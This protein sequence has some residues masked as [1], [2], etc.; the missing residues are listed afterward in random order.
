[1]NLHYL[2]HKFYANIPAWA[3]NGASALYYAIPEAQRYGKDF[4][5]TRK[6]LEETE[7]SSRERIEEMVNQR[8][9][10]IVREAWEHVPYYREKYQQYGID[11]SE[12]KDI[13]DIV[14]L[15]VID[16]EEVRQ[17]QKEMISD[18]YGPSQ[19]MYLTTSG[20]TGNPLGFYQSKTMVMIEWAY[21]MHIWKRAG[22]LPSNS[23]LV[24]RG[25]KLHGNTD[26]QPYFYDPLR[27]ELSCDIFNMTEQNMESYCQAIELYHPE[28]I[29]GYMSSIVML[30]KYISQRNGGLRHQFKGVLAV[31]ENILQE[32]RDFVEK[33]FGA[34]VFSFYGHTERLIIAGECEKSTQYHIEPLYGYC[35]LL[36]SNDQQSGTGEITATGFLNDAMPFIRYRTGDRASFETDTNCACGRSHLRWKR[37]DGRD[38]EVLVANDGSIFPLTAIDGIHTSDF[39]NIIRYRFVQYKPGIVQMD[40]VP[41]SGYIAQNGERI[42]K[43]LEDRVKGKMSIN[44]NIQTAINIQPNGK[45]RIIE[46]HL[47]VDF[48]IGGGKIIECKLI[49]CAVSFLQSEVQAA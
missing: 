18:R 15:P 29:H 2:A 11:I 19:L 40:I 39:D 34:R 32:Q 26:G 25:K 46:Q 36:D 45:Y 8:F 33:L 38:L 22:C 24:L 47:P 14:K 23:R 30:A 7:F 16:K 12:I 43:M 20:S 13:R 4:A 27:K 5:A 9:L 28:F 10:H 44:I 3:L 41:S 49:L 17:H 37:I 1:M 42:K 21:V 48:K 31:S 6:L 35:E